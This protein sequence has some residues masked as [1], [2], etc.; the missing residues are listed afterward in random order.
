[1][2]NEPS[3]MELVA[4]VE[5]MEAN[6]QAPLLCSEDEL[7]DEELV[8]A[9]AMIEGNALAYLSDCDVND[10]F[11]GLEAASP[12]PDTHEKVLESAIDFSPVSPLYLSP[13]ALIGDDIIVDDII[14]I[15]DSSS[16][17]I[18]E[19]LSIDSLLPQKPTPPMPSA[20][21]P[22][23][24][25]A[26]EVPPTSAMPLPTELSVSYSDHHPPPQHPPPYSKTSCY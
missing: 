16:D 8:L 18:E 4:A 11:N 19:M 12:T 7:S 13:T 15:S 20:S 23:V 2:E 25:I 5:Q 3:D 24:G 21:A 17:S 14:V 1:M 10:Y 22:I 9:V 26:V 6:I